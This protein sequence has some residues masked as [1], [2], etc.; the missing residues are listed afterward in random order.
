MACIDLSHQL[1]SATAAYP[2]DP[3]IGVEPVMTIPQ[4]GCRLA[5][6]SLSTHSATHVDA[7][8]HVLE[9]G[10]PLSS[11][12]LQAFCG[13]ACVLDCRSGFQEDKSEALCSRLLEASDLK[14]PAAG[15]DWVLFWTGWSARWGEDDYFTGAYP[16]PPKALLKRLA[17]LG[18]TGIGFDTP[19]PDPYGEVERHCAW[20]AAGGGLIAENLTNLEALA[21]EGPIVWFC[22]APLKTTAPDGAPVRAFALTGSNPL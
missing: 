2:G 20:F 16:V 5:R 8:A 17:G 4:E 19:G 7:P 11:F 18:V 6:L 22:A 13:R 9:D 10:K 1:S 12:A 15:V 3:A 14:G 21:Q